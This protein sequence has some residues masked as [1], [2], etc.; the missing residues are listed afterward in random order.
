MTSCFVYSV[1][2]LYAHASG[3]KSLDV[4][5]DGT[6]VVAAGTDTSGRQ[7]IA[8]WAVS[9]THLRAHET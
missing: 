2:T 6:A 3:L 4:S 5:P 7:M 1:A 8:V 9:Y